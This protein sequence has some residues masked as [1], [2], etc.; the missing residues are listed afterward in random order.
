MDFVKLLDPELKVGFIVGLAVFIL[1]V[2]LCCCHAD[3]NFFKIT[4]RKVC[5]CCCC[6][7]TKLDSMEMEDIMVE[8]PSKPTAPSNISSSDEDHHYYSTNLKNFTD[9][10]EK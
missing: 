2:W 5:F 10:K 9:F 8:M 3:P 4:L 1:I 6:S 7:K